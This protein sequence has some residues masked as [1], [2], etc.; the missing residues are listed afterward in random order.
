MSC[1][2]D[3]CDGNIEDDGYCDKCGMAPT[4]PT[5]SS[6]PP[7][8][9]DRDVTGPTQASLAPET[10]RPTATGRTARGPGVGGRR[11]DDLPEV[12]DS[13]P[14]DALDPDPQVAEGSRFCSEC[15]EPVGRSRDGRPGRDEGF[16][17]S[18]GHPFSFRPK[19]FDGD[20][21]AN[22]Y[23]VRGC[24]AHGGLGWIY[25]AQDTRVADQWVVLKGLLNTG[26][27]DAM[28]VAIAERRYLASVDHPDIV[29]IYNF[30]EHG[31]D[32]YLVMEYVGGLSLKKLLQRQR[33]QN[34]GR[35]TPL[36]V[37]HAIAYLL[38]MLPALAYLHNRGMIYC[39]FKPDNVIRT[40]QNH[41]K[42]IDLGAMYRLDDPSE[43]SW[44]TDG[45][46]APEVAGT[47]PTVAS[48]LFTV[49]RTLAVLCGQFRGYQT[50]Y[51][52]T[53]PPATEVPAFQRFES[54]YRFLE[55]AT[56]GDPNARF[57][58][59][60]EMAEQLESLLCEVLAIEKGTPQPSKSVIF[61]TEGR[62]D[63]DVA[64]WRALPTP[65]VDPADPAASLLATLAAASSRELVATLN[66]L[67]EQ[68]VEVK[69]Q[70]VRAHVNAGDY[71][72][73]TEIL[74][75]VA[76]TDPW[77]Y[78]VS[79]YAGMI[80]LATNEPAKAF[81]SFDAV[82]RAVPG[83]L[84]PKLALGCAAE[85]SGDPNAAS[86]WYDRVS[87]TDPSYTTATFGLARCAL[88]VH[89]PQEAIDAYDRIPESSHVYLRAQTAKAYVLMG[90]PD[91]TTTLTDVVVAE[92]V[93]RA[94][95]ESSHERWELAARVFEKAH[96]VQKAG[97]LAPASDELLGRPFTDHGIRLGR[98]EAYRRLARLAPTASQ[99]IALVDQ[100]NLVRPRTL[101]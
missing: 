37:S 23:K 33:E 10:T 64:D 71:D 18:C 84:A 39:D 54:L 77:E 80:A 26:D 46:R 36:P 60:G 17:T 28:A 13:D 38:D 81:A 59:A 22:Q 50:T 82:H 34:E 3:G 70:L 76:A 63:P 79:W 56:A 47:G 6:K 95:P 73:A 99:R 83:E 89:R 97:S 44:G 87:R 75:A 90:K 35:P 5:G 55:R 96:A 92:Y 7:E 98:E 30:V 93:V 14:L 25:L 61:T 11:V 62:G 86:G 58:S 32:G 74:N 29:R 45:Y 49:G 94:L 69:L 15:G 9:P 40:S 21:V 1:E 53:L 52:H 43:Q 19:L 78:R 12:P 91:E 31:K 65:L 68:T 57:Q 8:E 100:A 72:S 51:K 24:L 2:R 66:G 20:L 42:L 41:S 16:C 88:A 85:T 27:L 67:P 101:T 48:D 4:G